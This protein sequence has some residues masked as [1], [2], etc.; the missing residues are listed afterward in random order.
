[1]Y[2]HKDSEPLNLDTVRGYIEHY[3]F[4]SLWPAR[5][6]PSRAPGRQAGA[7]D[8][9]RVMRAKIEALL[10]EDFLVA[11]KH[12]EAVH[13]CQLAERRASG[14]FYSSPARCGPGATTRPT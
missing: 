13:A 3:H 7:T 10:A 5:R 8:D 4:A 9:F 12:G 2:H 14:R 1:M 11:S 6:D